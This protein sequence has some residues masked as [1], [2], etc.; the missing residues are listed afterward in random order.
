MVGHQDTPRDPDKPQSVIYS[1]IQ[2][3]SL[4]CHTTPDNENLLQRQITQSIVMGYLK[5]GY[6]SST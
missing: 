4:I 1:A 3:Q 6:I 5:S 2:L